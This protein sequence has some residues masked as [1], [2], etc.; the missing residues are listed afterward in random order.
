MAAVAVM[1]MVVST[2]TPE[3]FVTVQTSNVVKEC[4]YLS[5]SLTGTVLCAYHLSN[6]HVCG[7]F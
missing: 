7:C 2:D 6:A 3:S 5:A 1:H 4:S